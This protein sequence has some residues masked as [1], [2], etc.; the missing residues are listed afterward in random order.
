MAYRLGKNRP[1]IDDRTMRFAT[2]VK[3]GAAVAADGGQLRR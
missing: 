2:Y 3:P 1:V